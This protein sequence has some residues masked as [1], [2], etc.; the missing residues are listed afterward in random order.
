LQDHITIDEQ[1]TAY[2]DTADVDWQ[3]G[4]P[5]RDRDAQFEGLFSGSPKTD[6]C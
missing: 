4:V 6:A 3:K 2:G 5:I 1:A